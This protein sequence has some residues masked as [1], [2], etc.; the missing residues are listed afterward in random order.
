MISIFK[1][2]PHVQLDLPRP[3][4]Q[5][6]NPIYGPEK[7]KNPQKSDLFARV[8][9]ELDS[10]AKLIRNESGSHTVAMNRLGHQIVG[11]E[12]VP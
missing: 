12:T 2:K 4:V 3:G 7:L 1:G 6:R 8:Y 5:I 10:K 9:A 11:A